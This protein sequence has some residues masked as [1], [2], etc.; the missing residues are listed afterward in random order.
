LNVN[1]EYKFK[2]GYNLYIQLVCGFV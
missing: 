2:N 1:V